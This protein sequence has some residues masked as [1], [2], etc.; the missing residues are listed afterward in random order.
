MTTLF[1]KLRNLLSLK[2][3]K[4]MEETEAALRGDETKAHPRDMSRS[5]DPPPWK[6]PRGKA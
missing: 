1:S 3:L 4:D 2:V 5:L 6:A